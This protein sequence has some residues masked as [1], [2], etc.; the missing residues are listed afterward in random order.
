MASKLTRIRKDVR[1]FRRL[2]DAIIL[3]FAV[4]FLAMGFCVGIFSAPHVQT[5]LGDVLSLAGAILGSAI[6]VAS[7]FSV[8]LF[9]TQVEDRRKLNTVGSL[10]ISLRGFGRDLLKP[11]AKLDPATHVT[12][13][14]RLYRAVQSTS[15]QLRASSRGMALVA[16]MFEEERV[17]ARLQHLSTPGLGINAVDLDNLGN[18][19]VDIAGAGLA[20]LHDKS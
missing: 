17:L 7:A 11:E 3:A 16:M 9:Q 1:A 6:A 18:E 8:V 19:V 12:A 14:L 15:A 5:S 4:A 13:A 10:L 20:A 2:P